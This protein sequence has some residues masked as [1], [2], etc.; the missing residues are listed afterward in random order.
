ML[1][2]FL[3]GMSQLFSFGPMLGILIVLPV[4]L[5]SGLLPGGGLPVTVVVLGFVG[6]LD[7]WVAL[8]VV[9]FQMAASDITEPVPAIMLGIPGARSAQATILDG[10]P[11]ARRGEAGIALG[12]SYT[13]TLVGGLIGAGL[14][15]LAIPV[16]RFLLNQFG[17]AEFFLLT[18]FGVMAVAV[19]SA[20]AV[21]KGMLAGSLGIVIAS[22]GWSATGRGVVRLD[23]G[24]DYLAEGI[25]LVPIVVGLFAIPEVL[26][27]VMGDSPIATRRIETMLKESHSDVLRGM[28]IAFRHKWLMA[29]S[30]MIGTFVA[31]LP[32]VGISAAHWIAYS[33]ARQTEKGGKESFGKGDVRGVI[34]A[35]AANNSGDGGVLIPTLFFGIPGSGGMA[36]VLTMLI[37]YGFVPGPSMLSDDLDLVFALIMTIVLGNIVVVPI[38]LWFSG[39]ITKAAAIPPNQ[40]FPII[41]VV[42]TLAAYQGTQ[43][44][45]DL[46]MTLGL[47]ALGIFMKRYGWPRPPILI[48]VVLGD[49]L[50]KYLW[51]SV[52]AYGFSMLTRPPFLILLVAMLAIVFGSMRV[53][54]GAQKAVP[55]S[56]LNELEEGSQSS[57][58]GRD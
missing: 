15:T 23:F 43:S 20:G 4:A 42:V 57:S 25:P 22:I 10:Y 56:A 26:D 17:L 50:E 16:S 58:R 12:A 14:L 21:V 24:N 35:D 19:V 48:A 52:Q 7:P 33:S 27:L 13:T 37:L 1:E 40:L 28:K 54:K 34:A 38:M 2:A 18:F 31:M 36:I 46:W 5:L 47:A 11:M 41:I 3:S 39:Y 45:A 55:I 30:S 49:L 29:R 6:A 32:G 53:N 8:T 44:L 51:L 9:V